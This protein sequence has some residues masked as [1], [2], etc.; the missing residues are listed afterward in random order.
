MLWRNRNQISDISSLSPLT[1]LSVLSLYNN[2]IS[3]ISPLVANAGLSA[4]DV[5]DLRN[6]PLSDEALNDYIPALQARGGEV[7]FT[8]VFPDADLE[9]AIRDA[10]GI[11]VGDITTTDMATLTFLDA[12]GR[13]IQNLTGLEHA[14][15]LTSLWLSDNRL[16]NISVLSSLTSLVELRLER[17]RIGDVSPLSSLV[18]LTTLR[19][20]GNQISDVSP[21]S[22]LTGLATLWLGLNQICDVSP[23]VA[24]AG[25][26]GEV[27]LRNNPLSDESLNDHIPGLQARGVTVLFSPR[28]SPCQLSP[29]PIPGPSGWVLIFLVGAVGV[30]LARRLPASRDLGPL[31]AK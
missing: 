23:L 3:D 6:N 26:S 9:A 18:N 15:S 8:I 22:A 10:L 4:G 1:N 11:P 31:S 16:S 27:D 28:S 5:V 2:Q 24:N 14:T 20:A 21:L 29:V 7:I 13:G 30:L 19:L 25:I 17:N 12:T